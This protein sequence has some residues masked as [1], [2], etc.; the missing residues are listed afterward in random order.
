VSAQQ[1]TIQLES[2]KLV[3]E[4]GSFTVALSGSVQKTATETETD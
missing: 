1:L 3:D 4:V 2:R